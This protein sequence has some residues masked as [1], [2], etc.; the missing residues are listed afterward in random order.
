[1]K[2]HLL[3]R[4]SG[5]CQRRSRTRD[6]YHPLHHPF[7]CSLRSHHLGGSTCPFL[8]LPRSWQSWWSSVWG[9]WPFS[10]VRLRHVI[11]PM[12]YSGVLH[13]LIIWILFSM[14]VARSRSW[15]G[16]RCLGDGFFVTSAVA[17]LVIACVDVVVPYVCWEKRKER[18]TNIGVR[19]T[20]TYWE[21]NHAPNQ[22]NK[23][24]TP[25]PP[26]TPKPF[27]T[28][29]RVKHRSFFGSLTPRQFRTIISKP[30]S[31]PPKE[32][33]MVTDKLIGSTYFPSVIFALS[34]VF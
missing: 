31:C 19:P 21:K 15:W 8:L 7:T 13:L 20:S 11:S 18:W 1:M 10:F 28:F 9:R 4:W 32:A 26:T 33:P 24:L 3:I 12:E 25:S 27:E 2:K 29:Y 34:C 6:M 16:I 22:K 5:Q 30:Q 17:F 14:N 23:N